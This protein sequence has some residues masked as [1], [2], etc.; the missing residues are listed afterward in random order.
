MTDVQSDYL[1]YSRLPVAVLSFPI[2]ELALAGGFIVMQ[3]VQINWSSW[4]R[5]SL[6]T[7]L[8]MCSSASDW[9]F[10]SMRKCKAE[11]YNWC[12]DLL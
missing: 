3:E 8:L 11:L 9:L 10:A 5:A 6:C 12:S 4:L 7:V 1:R 2:A